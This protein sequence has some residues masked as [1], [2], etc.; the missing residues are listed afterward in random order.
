MREDLVAMF[1][2]ALEGGL[3]TVRKITLLY[4]WLVRA[5]VDNRDVFRLS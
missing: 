2:K 1:R 4:N 5:P 3:Q